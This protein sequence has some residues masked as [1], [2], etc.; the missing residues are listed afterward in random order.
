[1]TQTTNNIPT[2]KI[3]IYEEAMCCPTGLCGPSIN[4]ELLRISNLVDTMNKGEN[5]K[6]KRYNLSESPM[7]F[8]E[9]TIVSQLLKEKGMACLP[10]TLYGDKIIK[11]G[12]YP[13]NQEIIHTLD[14]KFSQPKGV[15]VCRK[16]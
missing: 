5:E 6:I 1:M 4:P 13:T 7:A 14:Y 11:T 8:V 3:E 15:K 9:N 2:K 10:L 16:N 12:E